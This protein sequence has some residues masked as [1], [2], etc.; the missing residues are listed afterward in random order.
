MAVLTT[1][2]R[3]DLPKKSFALPSLREGGK[4]GYPIPDKSHARNALARVSQH[5]TSS[6]KAT[7]RAKVHAKFPTISKLHNGGPVKADGAYDLQA[8]EHVLT[9]SEA[10]KARQHALMTSGMKSLAKSAAPKGTPKTSMTIEPM[11]AKPKTFTDKNLEPGFGVGGANNFTTRGATTG[12]TI[13]P[14]L[15][16]TPKMKMPVSGISKT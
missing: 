14:E 16:A 7:V 1:Q 4:G 2:A 13:K 5:R 3:K 12:G 9:A 10:G 6:Q 15:N 11:P 8:G